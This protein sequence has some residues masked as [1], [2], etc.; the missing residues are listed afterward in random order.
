MG[1]TMFE[2]QCTI[3]RSQKWGVRVELPIDE[4]VLVSSMSNFLVN[5]VKALLGSS[6]MFNRSK[7]KIGCSSLNTNR[8]VRLMF[9]KWCSSLFDVQQMV[10]GSSLIGKHIEKEEQP[11]QKEP[12]KDTFLMEDNYETVHISWTSHE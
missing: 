6:S 10:F 7:P 3:I 11:T 8:W 9:K 1:R 5:L 4:Q 2:V 12:W